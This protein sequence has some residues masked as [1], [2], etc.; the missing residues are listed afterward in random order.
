MVLRPVIQLPVEISI[1]NSVSNKVESRRDE[2]LLRTELLTNSATVN[3][4]EC[5]VRNFG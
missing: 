2:T 1:C 4:E 3:N 5:F